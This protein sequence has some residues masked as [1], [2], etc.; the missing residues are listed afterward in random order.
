MNEE[1]LEAEPNT[2]EEATPYV[3]EEVVDDSQETPEELRA[4]LA[5]AEELA[6]N[7]KVRAER[8]EKKAKSEASQ[9]KTQS[10]PKPQGDISSTDLYV[11][12][13]NKVPQEDISD[14]QEYANLK[15]ISIGEALKS[16]VV[17]TILS[18]KKEMRATAAAA[19]VGPAKRSKGQASEEALLAKASQGQMPDSDDELRR[20][21]AARRQV[22]K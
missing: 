5:K 11:L 13:E 20:L 9:P 21:V 16:N 18:D 1:N 10:S 2:A 8:A 3:E 19:N 6:N 15:G 17:K 14:V 7:Y 12:I 22:N 4:R